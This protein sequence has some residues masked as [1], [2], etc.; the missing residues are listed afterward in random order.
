[1]VR[2][3]IPA[4]DP[5]VVGTA[6]YACRLLHRLLRRRTVQYPPMKRLHSLLPVCLAVSLSATAASSEPARP[7]AQSVTL[8]MLLNVKEN[9][10]DSDSRIN[11]GLGGLWI[12]WRTGTKPLQVNFN[13]SGLPDGPDVDPPR[14]DD[15]TDLRYLHN[16]LSWKHAHAQDGQFDGEIKRFTAIVKREFAQTHNERGWM[17]DELMDMARLSGDVFYR[18]TARG[19]A[20]FYAT[21]MFQPDIGAVYKQKAANSPGHYRV[22]LALEVGCALVQAGVEFKQPDWSSKGE[23]LVNFAY[24]HAYLAKYHLFL[25][26][27]DEVRLPDGTAN[28]NE[29]IYRE[30]FR[31]Y[32]ADGGTVRFGSIG[33][34]AL[35]LLHAH[36]VTRN[37][38]YLE[39]A[40]DLLMPL[41]AQQNTLGLWDA[42]NG[43]YF[44]GV[45][46]DGPDFRNPGKPKLLDTKKE[47][48]RQFHML[49]AFH[50][51]NH[52][53]DG[54]YAA[55][56]KAMLNVLVQK[57]Y[58][59][60][61]H[62]ILYE[63]APDWSPLKTK[64][65]PG[66]LEDWVTS[67][68]MGCA[69]LALFSLNQEAPW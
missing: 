16:L 18:E 28:P 36:I 14:H 42:K 63:V 20:E 49:Q 33:Q 68:A 1:V 56:E 50:V 23:R 47:S 41:T 66:G 65:T 53:T 30:R 45:R 22:D 32:V 24:D 31:N 38:H 27:M 15:L 55:M 26:Q 69:M 59:S 51:A 37:Q 12:N 34:I 44:N 29:K 39:R 4:L 17:Y 2:L 5:C 62:G 10:L 11:G 8:E 13:G 43:G 3:Q 60:P 19:L 35:S 25:N 21:K 48:G 46:F 52:L 64:G 40:N 61:G 67:E 9:G 7:T 54:K 57:A 6:A 58:Y